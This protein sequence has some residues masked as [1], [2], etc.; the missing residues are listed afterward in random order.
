MK[1]TKKVRKV[2]KRIEQIRDEYPSTSIQRIV[3]VDI[4]Y[5]VNKMFEEAK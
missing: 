5:A 4:L 2:I 1:M 3:V